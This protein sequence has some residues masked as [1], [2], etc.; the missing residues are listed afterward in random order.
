VKEEGF[1][2]PLQI[3]GC[4][5]FYHIAPTEPYYQLPTVLLILMTAQK[6]FLDITNSA[7]NG[8]LGLTDFAWFMLVKPHIPS[9]L[10]PK[11]ELPNFSY[12]WIMIFS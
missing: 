6:A 8:L 12:R 2:K 7:C 9:L 4:S 11:I 1:D 3:G 5:W 10:C